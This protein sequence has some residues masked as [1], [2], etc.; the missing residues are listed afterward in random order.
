[1]V[2]LSREKNTRVFTKYFFI[3]RPLGRNLSANGFHQ[4]KE[5]IMMP[6]KKSVG[7]SLDEFLAEEGLLESSQSVAIKRVVSWQITQFMKK[8]NLSKAAMAARMNTSRSALDR[9]L[10]PDNESVTLNT[11]QNAAR[12]IG[13]H[14][15]MKL[16]FEGKAA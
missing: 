8:Q 1:M 7:S 11:L 14:L 13:A 16:V 12:A 6:D 15:E 4:S 10:D 3:A 9:L 2:H 5:A